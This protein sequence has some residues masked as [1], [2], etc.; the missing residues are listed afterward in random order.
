MDKFKGKYRISSARLPGYD[1]SSNGAYFLTICTQNREHFFGEI[2]NGKMRLSEI[3][4]IVANEWVKS[5]E[6]RKN[7]ELGEWVV[8]PNHFHG[9]V[10]I[11]GANISHRRDVL[12]KRL[13]GYDGSHKKMSEISPI[14][15]SIPTIIRFFKRQTTIQSKKINPNFAWQPRFHDRIIRNDHELQRISAYIS[16][17]VINWE[18]D[19]NYNL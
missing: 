11:N 16:I 18:K 6:L 9:I 10:V 4:E 13:C 3:G 1:Y 12:T 14:P 2:I 8:M 7:V 19:A 5:P 17:N 15:N